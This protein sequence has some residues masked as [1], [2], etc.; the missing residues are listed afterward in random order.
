MQRV[1]PET[2]YTPAPGCAADFSSSIHRK[3]SSGHSKYSSVRVLKLS[4]INPFLNLNLCYW[5]VQVCS[6][7]ER[8]ALPAMGFHGVMYS[9][10]WC[11]EGRPTTYQLEEGKLQVYR[12][13]H[14]FSAMTAS[15]DSR[16]SLPSFFREM[17]P[18]ASLFCPCRSNNCPEYPYHSLAGNKR[19]LVMPGSGTTMVTLTDG[20]IGRDVLH[21]VH[22]RL[23]YDCASLYSKCLTLD[24]PITL[25]ANCSTQC[26]RQIRFYSHP[27]QWKFHLT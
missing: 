26:I 15:G 25:K 27:H 16:I 2:P 7:P 8:P 17:Q 1:S 6:G 24:S 21:G 13:F 10:P 3:Q 12:P 5:P 20:Q 22:S 19:G 14:R 23:K 9:M 11:M 4:K 18:L